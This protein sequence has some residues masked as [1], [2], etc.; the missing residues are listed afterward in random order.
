M[1]QSQLAS[2][3]ERLHK[4]TNTPLPTNELP[5]EAK[6]LISIQ[7]DSAI[8]G[9]PTLD[10]NLSFVSPE[11]QD[12]LDLI[13][14]SLLTMPQGN[15]REDLLFCYHIIQRGQLENFKLKKSTRIYMEYAAT[16][17]ILKNASRQSIR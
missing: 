15:T 12:R 5:P 10:P 17:E 14:E 13:F 11:N 4:T 6:A 3:V 16:A 7:I 1:T 2:A 9:N 8:K